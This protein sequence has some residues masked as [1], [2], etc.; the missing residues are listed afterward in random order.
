MG[1]IKGKGKEL[2]IA[3]GNS[4]TAVGAQ[5]IKCSTG[6]QGEEENI[7]YKSYTSRERNWG[8]LKQQGEWGKR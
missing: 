8:A 6:S 1:E 2:G 5:G 7:E 3:K 4:G